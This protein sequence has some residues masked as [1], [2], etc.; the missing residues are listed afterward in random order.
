MTA[1]A[2]EGDREKCLKVGMDD[3]ISKPI[4]FEIMFKMIE[5]TTVY[6]AERKV[7]FD[8]IEKDME[9][10]AAQTGV[11][12]NETKEMFQSYVNS[13]PKML[14]NI[15]KVLVNNDF[16]ELCRFS[17]QLIGSSG[18]LRIKKIYELAIELERAA[19]EKDKSI[20]EMRL[21]DIKKLF[22]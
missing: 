4:D 12:M 10:F 7:H 17:H 21:L 16:K 1:N 22:R 11:K 8:F 2:M 13:M 15:E 20:C 3:Y 18:N 14:K 6:E 5:E 9:V 19:L